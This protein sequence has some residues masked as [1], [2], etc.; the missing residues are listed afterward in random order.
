MIFVTRNEWLFYIAERWWWWCCGA[1][2]A[3]GGGWRWQ[4]WWWYVSWQR[5]SVTTRGCDGEKDNGNNHVV[6]LNFEQMYKRWTQ[7]SSRRLVAVVAHPGRE[8]DSM[9]LQQQQQQYGRIKMCPIWMQ[10]RSRS[11]FCLW[12]EFTLQPTEIITNSEWYIITVIMTFPA[13]EPSF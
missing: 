1:A 6:V 3:T 13:Q 10:N 5:R 2:S 11:C 7:L 4:W 12:W 8:Y 9:S